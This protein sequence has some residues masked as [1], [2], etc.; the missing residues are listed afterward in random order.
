MSS[1]VLK[2]ALSGHQVEKIILVITIHST[3][4][5]DARPGIMLQRSGGLEKGK[6]FIKG[7]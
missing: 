6:Y 3:F 7:D 4:Y 5:T 1:Q 2:T